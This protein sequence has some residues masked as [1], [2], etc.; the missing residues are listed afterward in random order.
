MPV[1]AS[2]DGGFRETV[3]ADAAENGG[4]GWLVEA[5]T[6]AALAANINAA[7]GLSHAALQKM[8]EN[9]RANVMAHYTRTTMCN[10]T[11]N[12]YR[13]LLP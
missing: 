6:S 10:R 8:G 7:L 13:E 5:D 12:V 9:G 4:S 1:I 3:I 11:L 2:D